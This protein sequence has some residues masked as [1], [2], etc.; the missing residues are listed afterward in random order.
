MVMTSVS[1]ITAPK[2]VA[3]A[4]A[5]L[6]KTFPAT[7]WSVD[8]TPPGQTDEALTPGHPAP[9]NL[10]ITWTGGPPINAV[11]SLALSYAASGY[12]AVRQANFRMVRWLLP[13]GSTQLAYAEHALKPDQR[14]YQPSGR[15]PPVP[16]SVLAHFLIGR[17]MLNRRN[18]P[19]ALLR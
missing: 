10:A 7:A 9:P 1:I 14:F 16:G 12:D 2:T 8:M 6:E 18:A 19:T 5:A 3:L 15:T 13:D 17:I 11:R 4:K